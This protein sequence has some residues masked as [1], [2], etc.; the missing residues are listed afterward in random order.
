MPSIDNTQKA[1]AAS[2][3]GNQEEAEEYARRAGQPDRSLGEIAEDSYFM[4][5]HWSL[6][7]G[8][9]GAMSKSSDGFTRAAE[10]SYG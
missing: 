1:M 2:A 7:Q 4:N 8:L 9:T 3:T 6:C 5:K 10:K